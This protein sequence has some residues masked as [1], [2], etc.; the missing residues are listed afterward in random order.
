MRKRLLAAALLCGASLMGGELPI[1]ET[2]RID[3]L[4]PVAM[5]DGVRLYADIYRPQR[6]GKFPVL[7]VRTP[8]GVQRD[9]VHET[10]IRFAQ[11]GY[12]VVVQ[13]VRGRYQSDGVWEPFRNEAQD[14]YDTIQWAA[15]QPWSNGKVATEGGSYLGHVQWRAASERPP[16]LVTAFPAVASTSIYHNWAYLGGAFRLSFNYGWG[17]VRMPARIMLPQYWHEAPY[18]PEELRYE[19]ILWTLPLGRADLASSNRAVQHFRDWMRHQSYDDYWRAISDEERFDRVQVPVHTWGGWFDIFLQGTINGFSGVRSKGATDKARRETKM[20][21]GPWGHGASQKFGDIDFGASA[22]RSLFER[23]IRWYGHYLNGEDNGIN[24]EPPVEIFYMGINR[25]AYHEDWPVP[26]S[27]YTPFYL[28]SGGS[29][30]SAR[31]DGRLSGEKPAGAPSDTY[32]YDPNNPA[33]TTGGN[34]C[35]GAPTLAGPRDQRPV[36]AR[37]DVLVYTS[38]ILREP[39]PIAGPVKLR[40]HASTDGR[41]TDWMA[42]LVDV[43]P[44]GYAM[45]VAEGA[46]RARFRRGLDRMELLRPN[47][48]YEFAVDLVGTANVFL[49]GHRIRVD[50][51]SSNFPQFDRN[52]NTGED[53]GVS[54]RVRV[55]RQTIFHTAEQP[56]HIVLPIVTLPGPDVASSSS[57]R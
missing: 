48:V 43:F 57:G 30:N 49:P 52:P 39:L 33:P 18:A 8:Y 10:K 15:A 9:G 2:V 11:R 44:T 26:G 3:S 51:T 38:D 27:R 12:A 35:C 54:E 29:A 22:M 45:N 32:A 7:V 17:V 28:A 13:D 23:E 46:L 6:D 31:G 14:G 1:S 47:E 19:T 55:A 4:V 36:E 40:L 41:D 21:I 37:H 5:R 42:K 25:W 34:N 56:S 24:R 50:V 16:S 53:L 20:T